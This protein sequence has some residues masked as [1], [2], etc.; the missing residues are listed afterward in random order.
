MKARKNAAAQIAPVTAAATSRAGR[1]VSQPTG[2]RARDKATPMPQ[3][4]VP[5]LVSMS[6]VDMQSTSGL[7]NTLGLAIGG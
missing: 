2:S 3:S 4:E 5:S 1:R 6:P 7:K